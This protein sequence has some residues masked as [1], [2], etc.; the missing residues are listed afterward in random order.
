MTIRV[1]MICHGS[2]SAT[3]RNAFPRDEPLEEHARANLAGLRER[4]TASRSWGRRAAPGALAAGGAAR[5][6]EETATGLGLRLNVTEALADWDLGAWAGHTLDEI[7]ADDP[8]GVQAWLADPDLAPH[9]GESLAALVMRAGRWLDGVPTGVEGT[10]THALAVT[11]PAVVRAVLTHAVQ[12]PPR[13]FWRIDV[14]PLA[15][16]ELSGGPGRWSLQL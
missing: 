6:V 2:T 5:R 11:H 9:G 3:R 10:I 16:T 13:T 8:A 4:L 12:A 7:L 1:L 14:P 15:V